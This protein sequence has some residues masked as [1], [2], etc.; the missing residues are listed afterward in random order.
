M[1]ALAYKH[2]VVERLT[3]P[4]L[5]LDGQ[6]ISY[7]P[8]GVKFLGLHI[9]VPS[10]Q[11]KHKF[12]LKSKLH[13]MLSK[14]DACPLTQRA[15]KSSWYTEL[16]YAHDYLGSQEFPISWVEKSLDALASRYLKK[17][18]GLARPANNAILYLPQTNGGLDLPLISSLHKKL[19]SFQTIP[20]VYII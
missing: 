18:S 13:A 6:P 8:D 20:D 4:A 11:S 1:Q 12:T 5:S 7:S 9:E 17:W 19:P 2:L 16:V 10:D 15:S 3:D 14:A